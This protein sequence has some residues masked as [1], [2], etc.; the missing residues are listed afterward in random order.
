MIR[1]PTKCC[2]GRPFRYPPEPSVSFG[3]GRARKGE[4]SQ[5]TAEITW[6]RNG[7]VFTDNRYS[8]GHQVIQ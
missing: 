4:M 3:A 1:L 2:T 6:E 7:A 5:Y 8:R